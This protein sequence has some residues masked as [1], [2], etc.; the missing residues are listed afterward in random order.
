MLS[1]GPIIHLSVDGSM[2]GDT[3]KL[4]GSGTI[5]AEAW[6]ESVVPMARLDIVVNGEV[7][8]SSESHSPTR[9]LELKEKIKVDKHSWIAARAGGPEYFG[10]NYPDIWNRGIFAHTSPIYVAVGGEWKMFDLETAQYMLTLIDGDLTYIRNS[11]RQHPAGHVTHHHG[12]KDHIA[13]LERPFYEARAA[14][15]NRIKEQRIVH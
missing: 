8:A 14:I 6:A 15:Q 11:S 1:G 7:V 10:Y 5:E 9:R 3:L 13:Y 2:V 12:Q 4:S